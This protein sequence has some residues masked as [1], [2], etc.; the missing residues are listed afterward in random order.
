MNTD[1]PQTSFKGVPLNAVYLNRTGYAVY[2]SCQREKVWKDIQK[3]KLIDSIL[4]GLPI[5]PITVMMGAETLNG[6][7]YWVVDGQQ[8]LETVLEFMDGKFVTGTNTRSGARLTDEPGISFMEQGKTYH[9]LSPQFKWRFDNYELQF[10][11]V[12]NIDPKWTGLLYRRMNIQ[13]KLTYAETLWSYDGKAKKVLN[14]ILNHPFWTTIY[15]GNKKRKQP[16]QAA[17]MFTMMEVMETFA[18]MTSPR[19][20]DVAAGSKDTEIDDELIERVYR[21]L[22]YLCYLFEGVEINNLR[23]IIPMYQSVL[24]LEEYKV[25]FARLESGCLS[26]WFM[27]LLE[28]IADQENA[29]AR[30]GDIF[31]KMTR[32]NVQ[33]Q[34]WNEHLPIILDLSKAVIKDSKRTFTRMDKIRAWNRQSGKC[35]HC[36]KPIRPS[37]VAHHIEQHDNGGSTNGDNCQIVHAKCHTEIH[38]VKLI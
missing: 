25:N 20:L 21:N 33:M 1:M 32:V 10:C 19:L 11:R 18:N 37:D 27:E 31:T 36:G 7:V 16:F 35:P 14:A 8:R 30:Q 3:Q 23:G 26:R 29:Y 15:T 22:T 13:V 6:E 28:E 17:I 5:P 12:L 9:E 4:R 2:P 38:T 34:F 24:L